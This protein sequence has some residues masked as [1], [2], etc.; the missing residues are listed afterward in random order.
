MLISGS[1]AA[2]TAA[3]SSLGSDNDWTNVVTDDQIY[4]GPDFF[5]DGT[6]GGA[7][8]NLWQG[9][10]GPGLFGSDPSVALN[11]SSGAGD[12]FGIATISG[13]TLLVL[14]DGY[15]S[16]A[17]LTGNSLFNGSTLADL[18]LTPG[19][20]TTWRWGS[21]ADAD[22]LQLVVKDSTPVPAPSGLAGATVAGAVVSRLRR[23]RQRLLR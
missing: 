22:S 2:N 17:T 13:T 23:L 14:P 7:D 9:I 8:I 18:G 20:T 4:V 16:G 6:G 1:G 11:P 21:G 19:S 5:G 10:S 12:F 15:T 3:L